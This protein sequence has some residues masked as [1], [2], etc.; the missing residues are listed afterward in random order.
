MKRGAAGRFFGRRLVAGLVLQLVAAGVASAAP[1][2]DIASGRQQAVDHLNLMMFRIKM[3][4]HE[5]RSSMVASLDLPLFRDYFALPE[6]RHNHYDAMGTIQLT[7][8]QNTV[9]K[10]MEEWILT[11]HKRFPIGETCLIDRHGQEHLRVVGGR[12][13]RPIHFSGAEHD[14]PFFNRSFGI[15]GGEVYVSDPYMSAD[16]FRW[17]VAF[18]SP[19]E[20]GPGDVPAFYHIEVPLSVHQSIIRTRDFGFTTYAS[21]TPN[22]DEEGR[23]FII[24]HQSGL[25]IADSAGSFDYE[26]RAERH[27]EKNAELPDYLPPE[28]LS[29]YLPGGDSISRDAEFLKG[30]QTVRQGGEGVLD[31]AVGGQTYVL[32]YAPIPGRAWSL[33]HFDP[34]SGKG[35]WSRTPYGLV[36]TSEAGSCTSTRKPPSEAERPSSRVPP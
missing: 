25:V 14:A 10:R 9:R 2:G 36:I 13:E 7:P 6:S 4:Y 20:L 28:R 35:F 19:V 18:T 5:A 32:A 22:Q 26:L 24:D 17:V 23:F 34:I 8:Q 3:F 33:V 21:A 30:L 29:D 12:V 15:K 27:P 11:L 31:L 16:S 1:A